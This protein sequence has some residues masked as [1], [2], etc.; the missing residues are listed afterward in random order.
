MNQKFIIL[1]FERGRGH[2]RRV[3]HERGAEHALRRDGRQV[4]GPATPLT[5]LHAARRTRNAHRDVA[6]HTS[7]ET[8]TGNGKVKTSFKPV[9]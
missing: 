6:R 2:R 3:E 5:V 9:S 1:A 4:D 7:G 8:R